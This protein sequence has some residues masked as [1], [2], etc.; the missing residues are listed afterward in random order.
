MNDAENHL[1]LAALDKRWNEYY[2]ELKSCRQEA[3]KEAVH[4]LRVAA[5][6]LLSMIDLLRAVAPAP[7]LQKLRT[8]F[9]DQL[10]RLEDLRDTQVMMVEVSEV[11]DDLP[12]AWPFLAHLNKKE[13]R[14]LR[15]TRRQIQLTKPGDMIK[16]ISVVRRSVVKLFEDEDQLNLSMF[17]TV[18]NALALV[19][20]R[21]ALLDPGRPATIHSLRIAFR[22][23]R[24]LVEIVHP[25]LPGYPEELLG[26]MHDFQA[27]MGDIQ[28]IEVLLDGLVQFAEKDA[29]FNP[30]P[31]RRFFR[32]RHAE[33]IDTFF[34]GMPKL[35]S[36]WRTS[37]TAAFPWAVRRRRRPSAQRVTK[38]AGQV[39][40]PTDNEASPE[41]GA[42]AGRP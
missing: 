3:S 11:L 22:K 40:P 20:Q 10:N 36:F 19:L 5:R 41:L 14:L 37:R 27:M 7:R 16:R 30:E 28:D 17:E 25:G 35:E 1:L 18:D 39:L 34:Q 29:S 23:L 15:E 6:R 4:D 42:Q 12:E 13:R 8:T 32:K 24:Y 21:A 33:A 38:A 9:K 31:V 2:A 26:I